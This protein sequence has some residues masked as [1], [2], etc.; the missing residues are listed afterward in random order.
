MMRNIGVLFLCL[1]ALFTQSC[2]VG[3]DVQIKNNITDARVLNVRWGGVHVAKELLPG[4]LSEKIIVD[5]E[6]GDFPQSYEVTFT[7]SSNNKIIY[8][9]TEDI[10]SLDNG[11]NLYIVLDDK[12]EVDHPND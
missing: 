7:L 3:G 10:Y 8:L 11:E 9:K 12:T 4:E 5:G 1:V 6:W 2:D